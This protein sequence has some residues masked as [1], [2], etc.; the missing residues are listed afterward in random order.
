MPKKKASNVERMDAVMPPQDVVEEAPATEVPEEPS[1]SVMEAP[2]PIDPGSEDENPDA[3]AP[4]MPEEVEKP[5]DATEVPVVEQFQPRQSR[6]KRTDPTEVTPENLVGVPKAPVILPPRPL[7]KKTGFLARDV[8]MPQDPGGS[9]KA[10][11]EGFEKCWRNARKNERKR[12][13]FDATLYALMRWRDEYEVHRQ[14][15][16]DVQ[17]TQQQ[18]RLKKMQAFNEKQRVKAEAISTARTKMEKEVAD[19]EHRIGQVLMESGEIDEE[20]TLEQK[21]RIE[22]LLLD[23]G[24][25][26]ECVVSGQSNGGPEGAKG[27]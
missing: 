3:E 23:S 8:G 20:P 9:M 12:E 18:A 24:T 10:L 6:F 2:A 15:A 25:V 26:E 7:G 4:A 21:A 17:T 1:E 13:L 27:A 14:E 22:N 16:G 5:E 19:L 11:R